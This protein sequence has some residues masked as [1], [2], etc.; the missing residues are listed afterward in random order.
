[1]TKIP[2]LS[3][4]SPISLSLGLQL[5]LIGSVLYAG[6]QLQKLTNVVERQWSYDMESAAWDKFSVINSKEYPNLQIPDVHTIRRN[7]AGMIEIPFRVVS[8]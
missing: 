7:H 2:S 5:A 6:M 3:K 4:D 1:M 8:N